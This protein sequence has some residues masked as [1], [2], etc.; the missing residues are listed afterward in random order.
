[1]FIHESP[2]LLPGLLAAQPEDKPIDPSPWRVNEEVLVREAGGEL[3]LRQD[4]RTLRLRL[5]PLSGPLE[6]YAQDQTSIWVLARVKPNLISLRCA[7][8]SQSNS[9]E[10]PLEIGVDQRVADDLHQQRKTSAPTVAAAMQWLT[11]EFVC[12]RQ[13]FGGDLVFA[14]ILPRAKS[15]QLQLVGRAW[16]V[17]IRRANDGTL[18]VERVRRRNQKSLDAYAVLVGEIRFV[19]L[20]AGIRVQ[21]GDERAMLE[22]SVSS[23]GTYLELWQ[24]YSDME[25]RREVQTAAELGA[26]RGYR[27]FPAN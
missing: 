20:A 17:D 2:L 13:G 7:R 5:T 24:L 18:L 27:I 9:L 6:G 12:E 10:R 26:L 3:L 23:Y 11:D 22:A 4:S 14:A 15:G 1:M 19:D 8:P 16:L 21:D 25:W